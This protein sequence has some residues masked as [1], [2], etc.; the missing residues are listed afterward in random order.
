MLQNTNAQCH[1]EAEASRCCV[2]SPGDLDPPDL[3]L[4]NATAARV[5][6]AARGTAVD[7]KAQWAV[8]SDG[9]FGCEVVQTLAE[10]AVLGG[11][12]GS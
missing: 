1:L 3:L 12:H 10:G 9:V 6:A 7:L 2:V 5:Y 4:V 11:G 8:S